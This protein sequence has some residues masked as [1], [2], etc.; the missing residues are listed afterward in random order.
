MTTPSIFQPG[1]LN[2]HQ[3]AP[4]PRRKIRIV[5]RSL[6]SQN[7][8]SKRELLSDEEIESVESQRKVRFSQDHA[9]HH[10]PRDP[11]ERTHAKPAKFNVLADSEMHL[12][13]IDRIVAE[14]LYG[15]TDPHYGVQPASKGPFNTD[16]VYFIPLMHR[17]KEVLTKVEYTN[18]NELLKKSKREAL[19]EQDK[20]AIALLYDKLPK[21]PGNTFSWD[22]PPLIKKV[23]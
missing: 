11:E 2:S 1:V 20:F 18:L 3:N 9:L 16:P 17:F 22:L 23:Y 6:T 7:P 12:I 8:V 21:V 14:C 15:R 13:A 4:Q 19:S 5:G 10:F